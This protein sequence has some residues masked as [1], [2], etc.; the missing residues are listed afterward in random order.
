MDVKLSNDLE[1]MAV[2]NSLESIDRMA[3]FQRTE[4]GVRWWHDF[5][6]PLTFAGLALA[7]VGLIAGAVYFLATLFG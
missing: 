6:I 1:N 4:D 7:L 2:R 3:E 5:T